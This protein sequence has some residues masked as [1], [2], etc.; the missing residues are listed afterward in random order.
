MGRPSV[1]DK[2]TV[3]KIANKINKTDLAVVK[4][5]SALA[6]RRNISSE[7]ALIIMA[8]KYRIGSS[9]VLKKLNSHQQMQL[10]AECNGNA[11]KR[12]ILN[13]NSTEKKT[14]RLVSN[15]KTEFADPYLRDSLYS[16]IPSE[17][18]S[19]M[20]VLENSIR[21]FITRILFNAFGESWWDQVMNKKS[22][23][24]ISTKVTDRKTKDSKNWYHSKRGAHEIYY[25]DYVELLKII[26]VFNSNFSEFF[27]KEA[28][29]NLIGKLE[30]LTPTRNV[31]AHNNPITTKDLDRLKVHARD[32]FAY[33]QHL[34]SQNF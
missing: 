11:E 1:L 32:W 24:S 3:H 28:T 26:R 16:N 14:I 30:E 23:E 5:V 17:G 9:S 7:V 19:I 10:N 2:K 34:K 6:S 20:F 15:N 13:S 33:M 22:L 12:G 27:K 4:N 18:Y 25:S 29:K 8:D 21:V 31:I